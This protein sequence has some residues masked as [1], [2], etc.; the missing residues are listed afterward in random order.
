MVWVEI[1]R[2]ITEAELFAACADSI[3][4]ADDAEK[5]SLLR[6]AVEMLMDEGLVERR[7]R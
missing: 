2:W 4:E 5:R 7:A 1:D 6:Q 3:P